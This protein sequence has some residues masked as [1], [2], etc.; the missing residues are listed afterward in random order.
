MTAPAPSPRTLPLSAAE[1][2]DGQNILPPDAVRWAE[3]DSS[4]SPAYS[5]ARYRA[6]SSQAPAVERGRFRRC[7]NRAELLADLPF[8]ED[9]QWPA[10]PLRVLQRSAT[11]VNCK[12]SLDDVADTFFEEALKAGM[13]QLC[14]SAPFPP[15]RHPA[16]RGRPLRKA[17][18]TMSVQSVASPSSQEGGISPVD[19]PGNPAAAPGPPGF[20]GR[21]LRRY[22]HP[23]REEPS[24]DFISPKG[25]L[26]VASGRSIDAELSGDQIC[27]G[28]EQPAEGWDTSWPAWRSS[29]K[30][31]WAAL[32]RHSSRGGPS[33]R[34]RPE[35]APCISSLL[36]PRPASVLQRHPAGGDEGDAKEEHSVRRE[37]GA[38]KVASHV[39]NPCEEDPI[40]ASNSGATVQFADWTMFVKQLRGYTGGPLELVARLPSKCSSLPKAGMRDMP[41]VLKE[42]YPPIPSDRLHSNIC[43]INALIASRRRALSK[44]GIADVGSQ[45]ST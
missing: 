32:R 34:R 6:S 13:L 28:N 35:S 9:P 41:Y 26:G 4:P 12:G 31:S 25:H 24:R 16:P 37:A 45:M 1:L 14:P 33:I 8:G 22:E 29:L 36:K 5:E 15:I 7:P 23:V 27:G 39:G 10:L 20:P 18:S 2:E 43:S 11:A 38:R 30:V 40:N 42:P 21:P 19:R 3:S 44:S 17:F